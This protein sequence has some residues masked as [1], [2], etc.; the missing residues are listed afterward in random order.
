MKTSP[1]GLDDIIYSEGEVLHA[2]QDTLTGPTGA[3]YLDVPTIGVGHTSAA[4]PPHIEM[5]MTITH[6]QSRAILSADLSKVEARVM[7]AFKGKAPPQNVA[8]GAVSFDFNTGGI[9]KASWVPLWLV[10]DMV[11][12]EAHFLEWNKPPQIIGRRKREADLIFRGKYHSAVTGIPVSPPATPVAPPEKPQDAPL[13]GGTT[14]SHSA[15]PGLATGVLAAIAAAVK[16]PAHWWMWALLFAVVSFLAFEAIRH[17]K[18][19][20]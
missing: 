10:G 6:E 17:S 18:K 15:G 12:A 16:D 19:K 8:D 14:I 9:F 7:L 13:A 2:Y 5:G 3:K 11:N 1:R 20:A 4:G